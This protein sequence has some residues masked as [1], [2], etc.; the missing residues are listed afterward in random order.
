MKLKIVLIYA[1]VALPLMLLACTTTPVVTV[2]CNDFTNNKHISKELRVKA[3]T[4]FTVTLPRD[5][6]EVEV[7]ASAPISTE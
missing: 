6:R 1:A 5:G 2:S 4:T 7:N 3:G